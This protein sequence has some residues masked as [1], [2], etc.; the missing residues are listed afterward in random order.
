[1]VVLV[2][3]EDD[4][5]GEDGGGGSLDYCLDLGEGVSGGLVSWW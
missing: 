1:M 2:K 5:E 4:D 3:E